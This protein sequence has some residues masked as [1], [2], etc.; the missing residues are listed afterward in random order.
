MEPNVVQTPNMSGIEKVSSGKQGI[1]S[2]GKGQ[3]S[4]KDLLFLNLLSRQKQA[5]ASGKS[6][7]VKNSGLIDE[8]GKEKSKFAGGLVAGSLLLN[9]QNN[10]AKTEVLL[11]G[12]KSDVSAVASKTTQANRLLAMKSKAALN[13]KG[14]VDID[15]KIIAQKLAELNEVEAGDTGLKLKQGMAEKEIATTNQIAKNS[16]QTKG[17][18]FVRGE[19]KF[20]QNNSPEGN[21][22]LETFS[23][24][25]IKETDRKIAQVGLTGYGLRKLSENIE[26]NEEESL[27]ASGLDA[28]RMNTEVKANSSDFSKI[29][30]PQVN[31]DFDLIMEQVDNGLKTSYNQQLKEMKIKLQ[32]EE[33]GEIEVKFRIENS[34]MKAEFVVES[35]VVK[36]ALESRFNQLKENL[37]EKG[38]NAQEVNVYVSSGNGERKNDS[39][40]ERENLFADKTVRG[41]NSKLNQ[42]TMTTNLE[43]VT[44]RVNTVGE[45]GVNILV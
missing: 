45:T 38:I 25:D 5:A 21:S 14:E 41:V 22:S 33:L 19:E 3:L 17:R 18:V 6:I 23:A 7:K 44:R 32:P 9:S 39:G 26:G 10:E 36:E 40:Y 34:V 30:Q 42:E 12:K 27:T 35:E 8:D 13:P 11:K 28:G 29:Q 4:E 24:S 2:P 1:K 20:L 43:T 37:L 15:N 16:P 31:H